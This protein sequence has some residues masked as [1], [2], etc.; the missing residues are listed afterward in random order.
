LY[1]ETIN[2]LVWPRR[3]DVRGRMTLG[4]DDISVEDISETDFRDV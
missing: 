2:T 1:G 3:L 4:I